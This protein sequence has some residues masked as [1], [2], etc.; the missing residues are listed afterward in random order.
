[1]K[2][3]YKFYWD[4]GR[5]GEVKGIFIATK[6]EVANIIGK[7]VYFGEILG[8]HSEIYNTVDEEDIEL[9]TD[10]QAI[11]E[12]IEKIGILPTGY[13]PVDYYSED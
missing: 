8:K 1:M 5:Q 3:I 13:N 11:I 4:Y 2:G 12:V 9:I 6:E 10:D 7:E